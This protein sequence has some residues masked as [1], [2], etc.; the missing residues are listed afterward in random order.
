MSVN[1]ESS[2]LTRG[3]G[4]NV[5]LL[6]RICGMRLEMSRQGEGAWTARDHIDSGFVRGVRDDRDTEN[7][8]GYGLSP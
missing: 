2:F 7:D 5:R 8:R 3:E 6:G 1:N 4:W